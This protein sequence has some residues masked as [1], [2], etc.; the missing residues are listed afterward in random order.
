[1]KKSASFCIALACAA[2]PPM[3]QAETG[4]EKKSSELLVDVA[5]ACPGV[6]IDLRYATSDNATQRPIYPGGARCMLRAS[7]AQRLRRAQAWLRPYGVSIKVWDA[8]RP[9]WAQR[10][11]WQLAPKR[12][13]VADPARGGSLHTWGVAVDV[14]L[15]AR[16]GS[17]LKMPTGFD[18][19]SSAA[20]RSYSG[21]DPI[22]A[23]NL[24]LLQSAMS[25]AGFMVMRDEWW[26]FV[27]SD[28]RD[29]GPI[30]MPLAP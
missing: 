4:G 6:R 21:N 25:S 20:A 2:A 14:T 8:Y 29:F 3:V 24:R 13:F 11:L 12:D 19:F 22:I 1:M 23:R 10:I 27:A 18:D 5:K 30:E 16:L 9:A 15:V 28:Y 7:V 17:E 26:H